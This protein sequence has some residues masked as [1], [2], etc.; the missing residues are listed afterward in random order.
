MPSASLGSAGRGPAPQDLALTPRFS[1]RRTRGSRVRAGSH[2]GV[3]PQRVLE[4]LTSLQ[5]K[6]KAQDSPNC[7]LS[8]RGH[9]E[10]PAGATRKPFRPTGSPR[11]ALRDPRKA[12]LLAG[13]RSRKGKAKQAS[14]PALT[15]AHREGDFC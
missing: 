11:R 4:L 6:K 8:A 14:L 9:A 13:A 12:E 10:L 5:A 3:C 2:Q 1:L 15:Q 7:Q